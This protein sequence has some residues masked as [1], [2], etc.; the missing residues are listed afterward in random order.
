MMPAHL[1]A[2]A[3][4]LETSRGRQHTGSSPT[5]PFLE[6]SQPQLSK[7]PMLQF[8]VRVYMTPAELMACTKDVSLVAWGRGEKSCHMQTY[9]PVLVYWEGSSLV[10]PS[11]LQRCK[12]G[13]T[14]H[15]VQKVRCYRNETLI[16]GTS[17]SFSIDSLAQFGTIF[18]RCLCMGQSLLATVGLHNSAPILLSPRLLIPHVTWHLVCPCH[19]LLG[20]FVPALVSPAGENYSSS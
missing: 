20:G 2:S 5:R 19:F 17:S 11:A 12:K 15:F 14:K 4:G 6:S 1:V 16:T 18:C 8:L 7:S 13:I 9:T 3:E 10:K